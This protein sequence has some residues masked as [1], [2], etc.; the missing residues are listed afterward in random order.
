MHIKTKSLIALIITL[1]IGIV[2]GSVGSG[3]YR[4]YLYRSKVTHMRSPQGFKERLEKVIQP[5]ASQEA[6]LQ[7][8][9]NRHYQRV[10]SLG[11]TFR[12]EI[13][14][15]N[16]IFQNDLKDLLKDEQQQRLAEYFEKMKRPDRRRDGRYPKK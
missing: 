12:H 16:L 11:K 4:S 8:K 9:M 1:I 6:E 15:L 3:M 2:I 13:D 5:E 7:E 14:S 10:D